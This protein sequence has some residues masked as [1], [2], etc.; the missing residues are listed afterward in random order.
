MHR[1][2]SKEAKS[3]S[4]ATDKKSM[5]MLAA[6]GGHAEMVQLLLEHN[7]DV[8]HKDEDDQYALKVAQD[9]LAGTRHDLEAK[10]KAKAEVARRALM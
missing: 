6:R 4:A 8:M 3:K 7:A 2:Q 9:R 10:I 5:L 1:Q